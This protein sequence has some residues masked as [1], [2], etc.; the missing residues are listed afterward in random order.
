M[1]RESS[2][3]ELES[4]LIYNLSQYFMLNKLTSFSDEELKDQGSYMS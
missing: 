3:L 1:H 2:I 4:N